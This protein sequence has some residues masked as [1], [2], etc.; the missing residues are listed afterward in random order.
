MSCRDAAPPDLHALARRVQR[1]IPS[2]G[3]PSKFYDQRDGI[4]HDLRWIAR[5]G[6]P[7]APSRSAD[8]S[9]RERRLAVLAR[10][11]ADEVERLRRLLGEAARARPRRRRHEV[12]HR[13]LKFTF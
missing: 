3:D 1:L 9:P 4:A 6:S 10:G 8:P 5:H 7:E 2:W 13:Q 11:L 12:D